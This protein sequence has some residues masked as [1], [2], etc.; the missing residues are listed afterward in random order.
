MA[1]GCDLYSAYDVVI[2]AHNQ[3]II[4]TDLQISVPLGTYGRIASRSGLSINHNIEVGAGV[5]DADYRGN[6]C[7]V[8]YNHSNQ[9]FYV[10][11][12]DRIAQ[13]ICT[14]I[15]LPP[16]VEIDHLNCTDRNK[17]GFGSTGI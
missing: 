15:L 8:L 5:I 9:D 1:A 16:I 13:L 2:P 17:N 10:K 6:V 12:G 3:N 4:K 14:R 7:I 11:A